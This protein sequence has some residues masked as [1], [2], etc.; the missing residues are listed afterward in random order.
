L[1]YINWTYF[2]VHYITAKKRCPENK[3]IVF[4]ISEV[5]YSSFAANNDPF[6]K[7]VILA[8]VPVLREI[9]AL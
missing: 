2:S 1:C 3:I 9:T 6:P 5:K 4:L 7:E 8:T